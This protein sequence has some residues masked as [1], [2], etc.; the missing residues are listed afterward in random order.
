MGFTN[1]ASNLLYS[2]TRELTREGVHFLNNSVTPFVRLDKSCHCKRQMP[3][4]AHRPIYLTLKYDLY[5]DMIAL[6][7]CGFMKYTCLPN[8]KYVRELFQKLYFTVGHKQTDRI[9]TL[10][11][12]LYIWGHKKA[13]VGIFSTLN[14][15]ME[16]HII[17]C[18]KLST[19]V[20]DILLLIW[21]KQCLDPEYDTHHTLIKCT[22]KT[23]LINHFKKL[24]QT[25]KTS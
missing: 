7:L 15:C 11:T 21:A 1:S 10:C 19:L 24:L 13:S 9:I 3:S 8:M 6:K 22:L 4:I 17:L 23:V 5:I 20:V 2:Y 14:S 16:C 18:L 12:Q 25:V